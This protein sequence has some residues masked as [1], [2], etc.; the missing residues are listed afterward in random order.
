MAYRQPLGNWI[1]SFE[2]MNISPAYGGRGDFNQRIVGT[3]VW[4]LLFGQLNFAWFNKY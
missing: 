3:Y 1:F 4:Y 2:D